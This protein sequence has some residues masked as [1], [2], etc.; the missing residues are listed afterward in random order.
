[1]GEVTVGIQRCSEGRVVKEI[2]IEFPPDINI[3]EE[4]MEKI[5]SVAQNE[6]VDA[7][8]NAQAELSAARKTPKT[9]ETLPPDIIQYIPPQKIKT[10]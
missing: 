7:L 4:E 9:T 6:I 8:R 5:A 2:R 1:M 10:L 3:T